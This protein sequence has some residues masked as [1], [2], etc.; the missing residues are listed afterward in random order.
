MQVDVLTQQLKRV[1]NAPKRILS[2][3]SKKGVNVA[4]N[5]F[6]WRDSAA[7]IKKH[8]ETES[9]SK[10]PFR[11]KDKYGQNAR[12]TRK[13]KIASDIFLTHTVNQ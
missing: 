10:I 6:T 7:H 13:F 2:A 1:F 11:L 3:K 12:M 9:E 8:L 5:H 4:H